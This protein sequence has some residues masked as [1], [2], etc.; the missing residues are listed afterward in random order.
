MCPH[1]LYQSYTS[2]MFLQ[3]EYEPSLRY[4]NG[5]GMPAKYSFQY[6][7]GYYVDGLHDGWLYHNIK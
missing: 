2:T 7:Y 4:E 5:T 1:E 3:Y 6:G